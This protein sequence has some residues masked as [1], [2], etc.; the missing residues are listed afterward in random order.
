M[1]YTSDIA[2]MVRGT[3]LFLCLR[4]EAGV[5]EYKEISNLR[6]CARMRQRYADLLDSWVN[7]TCSGDRMRLAC[8]LAYRSDL[9]QWNSYAAV[10]WCALFELIEEDI[11]KGD[12]PFKDIRAESRG[13]PQYLIRFLFRNRKC[14]AG[15]VR[16][17]SWLST[18][19]LGTCLLVGLVGGSAEYIAAWVAHRR[20]GRR[21]KCK[22][23]YLIL[24]YAEE[25]N[26]TKH[27]YRWARGMSPDQ[28]TPY[29]L[30]SP[31]RALRQRPEWAMGSL[32]TVWEFI[33]GVWLGLKATRTYLSVAYGSAATVLYGGGASWWMIFQTGSRLA[34]QGMHTARL[35]RCVSLPGIAV[36]SL[37]GTE[38]ILLDVYLK[39]QNVS[40]VHWLHGILISRR[41][42]D[43]LSSLVIT[44]CRADAKELH[45]SSHYQKIMNAERMDHRLQAVGFNVRRGGAGGDLL[46]LTT[47]YH[48]TRVPHDALK[49]QELRECLETITKVA[50]WLKCRVI[51]R[52]HPLEVK[53]G[54]VM[55]MMPHMDAALMIV[56]HQTALT[57][58]ID[59]ARQ[60]VA[61]ISGTILDVLAR[62]RLPAVYAG[63]FFEEVGITTFLPECIQFSDLQS[64]Q[65]VMNLLDSNE[66]QQR[67]YTQIAAGLGFDREYSLPHSLRAILEER[68]NLGSDRSIEVL[69]GLHN[70]DCVKISIV[71][72]SYNQAKF[73]DETIRS[74]LRQ[75]YSNLEYIVADGGSTDGSLA[76]IDQYR[77]HLTK[78]INGPD[79]GAADALNKGFAHA[80][81]EIL[82]FLNSDDTLLPGAVE[83]VADFMI[84]N[85]QVDFVSGHCL[86]TNADGRMLRTTY[87]DRFSLRRLAY[88][89]CILLQPATFF[90]R[91]IFERSPGF[92]VANRISWDS[93][94]F[95]DFGMVGARHALLEQYLATYRLHQE[96]ITGANTDE[97]KRQIVRDRNLERYLGRRIQ[98]H[99]KIMRFYF[100]YW[101]KCLNPRDTWQRIIGGPIG[102]RFANALKS[103]GPNVR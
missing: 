6:I 49:W 39:T 11:G 101:R 86:V 70:S 4:E 75:G 71:T 44:K 8:A 54:C 7:L 74:V 79:Q 96:S 53:A 93:E 59:A 5:P 90:R 34:R 87:S 55:R 21:L 28:Y 80:T 77:P 23:E 14:E 92:N 26:T 65:G 43:G 16:F 17:P 95:L 81:G 25:E 12:V 35:R 61:T 2:Y 36:F 50:R 72:I 9:S 18:V 1:I 3:T 62:G 38:G 46:L 22:S 45:R 73:I 29:V 24:L 94:K 103:T 68:S 15:Q 19:V 88:D 48:P 89:G 13:M 84:R 40:S 10:W 41:H 60:V 78:V 63:G 33:Q 58:Q 69:P 64:G 47:L 37:Q 27:V 102:G 31:L 56:D 66:N 76:I 99:D 67:V 91:A 51:W 57:E 98:F 30:G 42:L 52:P 82:G 20:F 97:A 83:A 85:P 100:R 32:P